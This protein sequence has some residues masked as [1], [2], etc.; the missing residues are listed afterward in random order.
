M[1]KTK[2]SWETIE[3]VLAEGY[4][5][6][7]KNIKGK[8]YIT[9]RKGDDEKGL[10]PFDEETWANI[11]KRQKEDLA[12]ERKDEKIDNTTLYTISLISAEIVPTPIEAKFSKIEIED[13]LFE[14]KLERAKIK[15]RDCKYRMLES[16]KYWEFSKGAEKLDKIYEKFNNKFYSLPISDKNKRL[17][18]H[19][20]ELL[21]FECD[22]FSPRK[23]NKLTD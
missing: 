14:I 10:G 23:K 2:T 6:R 1:G 17:A 7:I 13:A 3:K 16:C 21:C 22:K 12:K 4:K 19:I 11:Q 15:G 8:K 20:N 5:V 9:A 18:Y